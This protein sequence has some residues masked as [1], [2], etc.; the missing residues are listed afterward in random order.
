MKKQSIS[1]ILMA[2]IFI[3]FISGCAAKEEMAGQRE[4]TTE[5][6]GQTSEA[7]RK[8]IMQEIKPESDAAREMDSTETEDEE[9]YIFPDSAERFMEKEE[10]YGIDHETLRKG[11]NEVYARHGRKFDDVRLQEYF[12]SKYWYEGT[13]EPDAFNEDVMN[14]YEKDNIQLIKDAEDVLSNSIEYRK[15]VEENAGNPVWL[16]S[17]SNPDY[18]LFDNYILVHDMYII[19]AVDYSEEIEGKDAGDEVVLR[20]FVYKITEKGDKALTVE[21]MRKNDNYS[22]LVS[23]NTSDLYWMDFNGDNSSYNYIN[24]WDKGYNYY[25]EALG[26]GEYIDYPSGEYEGYNWYL[27][28]DSDSIDKEVLYHGDIYFDIDSELY[29]YL[30]SGAVYDI[31]SVDL[32]PYLSND[33]GVERAAYE[34]LGFFKLNELG[35]IETFAEMF[36]P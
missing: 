21:Y 33:L 30:R 5:A 9:D 18:E 36:V 26:I 32:I 13:A 10:L 6:V 23:E 1:K 25:I 8:D 20:G 11:R 22:A 35:E 16:L 34:I 28:G 29:A 24:R 15:I 3:I 19:G 2:F 27:M 12:D 17:V 7:L 4:V 14:E 31:K